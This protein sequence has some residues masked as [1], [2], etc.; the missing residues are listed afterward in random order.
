V[1][2]ARGEPGLDRNWNHVA[3]AFLRTRFRDKI[4]I[5]AHKRVKI[6]LKGSM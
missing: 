6:R 4:R 1:A 2:A 3:K 5:S